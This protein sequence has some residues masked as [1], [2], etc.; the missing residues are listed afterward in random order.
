MSGEIFTVRLGKAT[1]EVCFFFYSV[2]FNIDVT[3]EIKTASKFPTG[4]GSLPEKNSIT[5]FIL[6]ST[7]QAE[8]G[9]TCYL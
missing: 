4:L 2:M 7:V 5:S 3:S 6:T 9:Y 1:I 8:V